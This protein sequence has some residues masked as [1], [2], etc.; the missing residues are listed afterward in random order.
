MKR[1]VIAIIN[2]LTNE[3]LNIENM[4][5]L[6]VAENW[7]TGNVKGYGFT[8]TYGPWDCYKVVTEEVG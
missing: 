2:T 5:F 8:K 6:F 7:A 1:K 3:N 4:E